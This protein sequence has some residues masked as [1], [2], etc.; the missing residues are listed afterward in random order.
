MG[1]Q[2]GKSLEYELSPT[3][4]QGEFGFDKLDECLFFRHVLSDN[5]KESIRLPNFKPSY[6]FS[7]PFTCQVIF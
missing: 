6:T 2:E 7:S 1:S 3:I 5:E 4:L